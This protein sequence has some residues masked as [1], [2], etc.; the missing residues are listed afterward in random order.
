ML[1]IA[2][3]LSAGHEHRRVGADG[4]AKQIF[5]AQ[6]PGPADGGYGR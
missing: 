6:T 4:Y 5:V 2:A 3:L 1:G